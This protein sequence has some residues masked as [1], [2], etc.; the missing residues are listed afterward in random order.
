MEAF[1]HRLPA[2]LLPAPLSRAGARETLLVAAT[3]TRDGGGCSGGHVIYL[4]PCYPPV[5]A[6]P[7]FSL[8]LSLPLSPLTATFLGRV[9]PSWALPLS[10]P[11][12]PSFPFFP[13]LSR[14]REETQVHPPRSLKPL[15]L[16]VSPIF[17]LHPLSA[18]ILLSRA[19]SA[20]FSLFLSPLFFLLLS[21]LLLRLFLLSACLEYFGNY[22]GGLCV[23]CF[24]L[25]RG[26][27]CHS[28]SF[29]FAPFHSSACFS[30][31]HQQTQI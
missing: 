1:S 29:L 8:S 7:R 21:I 18:S 14:S 26:V 28:H 24:F 27:T 9:A 17:R 5:P 15:F 6:C 11:F 23:E 22:S 25:S 20:H 4:S 3:L 12:R 30:S 31:C 10:R 2:L 16:F 19:L 13:S